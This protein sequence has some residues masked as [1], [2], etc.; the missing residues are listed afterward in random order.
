MSD[1]LTAFLLA[2]IAE[3]EQVARE[4][5]QYSPTPWTAVDGAISGGMVCCDHDP[6][7]SDPD[8]ADTYVAGC[9]HRHDADFIARWDPVR[10]LAECEAKRQIIE[11]YE[12]QLAKSAENSMEED[13]AWT[14]GPIVAFLAL[15]Y[16]DHPDYQ[17]ERIAALRS[18]SDQELASRPSVRQVA[19]PANSR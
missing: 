18:E 17:P 15:P 16:T 1:D 5:Q 13:R 12:D 8:E 19:G 4:V 2:C 11:L 9:E 10:V 6:M 7:H 3:D 14:L